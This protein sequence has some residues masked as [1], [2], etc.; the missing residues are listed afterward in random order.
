VHWVHVA[1]RHLEAILRELGVHGQPAVL[2][3]SRDP[4]LV[5]LFQ[6]IEQALE[7][8]YGF[9][10]L[11]YA[12]RILGHLLGAMIHL[13]RRDPG[14]AADAADRV[15]ASSRRM[16][17]RLHAPLDVAQL[18]SFANLSPS[19]YTALFKRLLGA[20]PRAYFQRLRLHR[21]ARLLLTTRH[22]IKTVAAVM[23]YDDPLYFSRVF[24]R[25]H[26]VSPSEYRAR[27]EGP[28]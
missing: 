12:C 2:R 16:M 10:E 8:D 28:S 13:R 17:Q 18:A 26:G 3:V 9:P 14:D 1:G 19:H 6:D 23:G 24:R 7:D 5:A 25:V 21:A 15:R 4:R 22:S 11:V 27:S 20:S